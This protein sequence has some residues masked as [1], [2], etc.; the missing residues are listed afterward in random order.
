M[1]VYK[2]L[3]IFLLL[4]FSFSYIG[5]LTRAWEDSMSNYLLIAH[6]NGR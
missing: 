2:Q 4:K 3:C 5:Y 1:I 6:D